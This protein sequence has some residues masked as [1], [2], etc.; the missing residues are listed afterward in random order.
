MLIEGML[1][2]ETDIIGAPDEF[3]V[4][5]EGES[6]RFIVGIEGVGSG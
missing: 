1:G 6:R 3:I 4:G 5:I 2:V